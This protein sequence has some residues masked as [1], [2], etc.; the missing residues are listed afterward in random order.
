MVSIVLL[1]T[2]EVL[3]RNKFWHCLDTVWIT[4]EL[5]P[6][7]EV[8]PEHA[9]SKPLTRDYYYA[10]YPEIP[11]S[12]SED[13][14]S[15]TVT[16]F[17]NKHVE[18]KTKITIRRFEA[19]RRN[20]NSSLKSTNSNQSQ[21]DV[22]KRVTSLVETNTSNDLNDEL[23]NDER[24]TAFFDRLLRSVPPPPVQDRCNDTPAEKKPL[25]LKAPKP[26]QELNDIKLPNYEE[27]KT[28]KLLQPSTLKRTK[29]VSFNTNSFKDDFEHCESWYES[30]HG[31][32]CLLETE[33]QTEDISYFN[34][35][36][37]PIN[38][39]DEKLEKSS[40]SDCASWSE[41]E[42]SFGFDDSI[43][44]SKGSSS[45]MEEMISQSHCGDLVVSD[46]SQD[47]DDDTGYSKFA[48]YKIYQSITADGD[49]IDSSSMKNFDI[50]NENCNEAKN[51]KKETSFRLMYRLAPIDD[52]D[53]SVN[54]AF[55]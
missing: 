42:N 10:K 51:S 50:E 40:I 46:L 17:K 23:R 24:V 9:F 41:I 45:N 55:T 15:I 5:E 47:D 43:T 11:R 25:M 19:K 20:S 29:R 16:G 4:E 12:E 8:K 52:V 36:R 37:S 33:A 14:H 21:H 35:R 26:D 1:T 48:I 49:V 39:L 13:E 2:E 18:W 28:D 34:D 31:I 30:I 22:L 54:V 27:F 38:Y 53:K 3:Q 6:F 32:S 44:R 7:E